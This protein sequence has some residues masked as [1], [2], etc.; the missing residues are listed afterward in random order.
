MVPEDIHDFDSFLENSVYYT[1]TVFI[2]YIVNIL[3]QRVFNDAVSA[4][5]FIAMH[6]LLILYSM[7]LFGNRRVYTLYSRCIGSYTESAVPM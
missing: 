5:F 6:S 1:Y 3:Q 2:Q 7:V 4:F